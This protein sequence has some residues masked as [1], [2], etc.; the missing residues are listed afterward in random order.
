MSRPGTRRRSLPL[1]NGPYAGEHRWVD[2]GPDGPPSWLYIAPPIETVHGELLPGSRVTVTPAVRWVYRAIFR[3]RRVV[4]VEGP[5]GE[6]ETLPVE[7]PL[8]F[9]YLYHREDRARGQDWYPFSRAPW[10]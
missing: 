10:I 5:D 9:L 1:F 2:V 7:G 3:S 6:Y 4:D 8:D